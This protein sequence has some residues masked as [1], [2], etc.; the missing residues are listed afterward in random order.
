MIPNEGY[1]LIGK[2]LYTI[3][4]ASRLIRISSSRIRRWIM[5]YTFKVGDE[6]HSSPP[7]VELGLRFISDVPLLSFSDL[8]E[9]RFVKAFL[10]R[11]VSWKTLR[12]ASEQAKKILKKDHPFSTGRF[13]TDGR[14]ILADVADL[15]G[16]KALL[17]IVRGQLGFKKI[18]SPFLRQLEFENDQAVRW[19]PL[20]RSRQ[21]VI[22]PNRSFGQPI[23]S[24]E[25]VPTAILFRAYR[26]ENTIGSVAGWFEVDP[27][28]VKD[29][30]EFEERLAA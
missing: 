16:D 22:D 29:A 21:V 18:I 25:G 19:W 4:E 27:G 10:D 28:A 1:H 6:V 9:I 13:V 2:G 14:T 8:Q 3:S 7:I 17:D 15:L 20:G 12:I 23:V 24:G 30:V 11:G 26:V 5:G